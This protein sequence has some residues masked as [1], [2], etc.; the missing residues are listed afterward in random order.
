ME[1]YCC[2]TII[3]EVSKKLA[4]KFWPEETGLVLRATTVEQNIQGIVQ[5]IGLQTTKNC[6][7]PK[8]EIKLSEHNVAFS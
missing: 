2:K 5:E 6:R 7:F 3:E 1:N 8:S 4:E